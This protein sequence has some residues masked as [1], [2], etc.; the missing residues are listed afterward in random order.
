MA[1]PR[2]FALTP[3]VTCL[4]LLTACSGASDPP[5][6]TP[7][8]Q[9][10]AEEPGATT[11]PEQPAPRPEITLTWA[12]CVIPYQG[13]RIPADCATVDFPAR[14]SAPNDGTLGV[15]VYRLAAKRPATK[16]LWMLNGGPGGAGF[17]LAP[18][19]LYAQ[20]IQ[21]DVDVYLVDHRGTGE[22]TFLACDE[23]E[24]AGERHAYARA[25]S[26]SLRKQ[27]GG[28]LDGFTATESANDVKELIAKVKNP[29]QKVFV[30]G[31]SYGSY[32]AHRL[33][34]LPDVQLDGV[35][36]D[37]NCLGA[38]CTFDTPQAFG[39]D[40]VMQN[41]ADVCKD[42]PACLS[43]IGGDPWTF[44]RGVAAKLNAGHCSQSYVGSVAPAHL[45]QYVGMLSPAAVL[46]LLKKIDRC[47]AADVTAIDDLVA[48]L[49]QVFG[50]MSVIKSGMPML[51]PT[52][53]PS[54]ARSTSN[55]L[56]HH[57]VA[58]ELVSRPPPSV[59][60]LQAK[61]QALF[62]RA[63][64]ETYDLSH[65]AAWSVHPADS[66][67]SGWVSR[68]VPWLVMQGTFDFQ[69][70]P[71]WSQAALPKIADPSLQFVRVDGGGHGVVFASAC[72]LEILGRFM[73]DPKAKVDARCTSE[74][75]DAALDT[76]DPYVE[77]LFDGADPW[78]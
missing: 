18:Y 19:A 34:Q 36:T 21:D 44:A 51:G 46:P 27:H 56:Y 29:A 5:I 13:E 32:W 62:F 64:P 73:E 61:N 68:D 69:T 53:R 24:E 17:E 20:Q 12:A 66:L 49:F 63:D 4:A 65:H 71:S 10:A 25:C 31:G 30:Y 58:S 76:T 39:V 33:L 52:P 8:P 6:E 70:L 55:A 1:L 26:A 9:T 67:R 28:N 38:T 22:S 54:E 11:E 14:R 40:E 7:T 59:A 47:N 57:V 2:L 48:R 15:A 72:S 45:V 60:A 16:Q 41:I 50:G 74:I 42:Q 77:Y 3:A 43:R 78:N 75:K 37:G 23:V 35:V